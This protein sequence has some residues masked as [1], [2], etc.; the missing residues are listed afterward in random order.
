MV[1][2]KVFSFLRGTPHS[3]IQD[4][5]QIGVKSLVSLPNNLE[6]PFKIFQGIQDFYQEKKTPEKKL[7]HS[8][9]NEIYE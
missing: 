7:F 3:R 2:N 1:G 6:K 4:F 9:K 8:S 5:A